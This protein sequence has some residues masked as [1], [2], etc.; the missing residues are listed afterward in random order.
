MLLFCSLIQHPCSTHGR[1]MTLLKLCIYH[2]TH[3]PVNDSYLLLFN[4]FSQKWHLNSLCHIILF[5]LL[6]V[7]GWQVD[8]LW[9]IAKVV[10]EMHLGDVF[11]IAWLWNT[12]PSCNRHRKENKAIKQRKSVLQ[13]WQGLS[14]DVGCPTPQQMAP[15]SWWPL[16]WSDCC[17]YL[18]IWF[19][20]LNLSSLIL[21][22]YSILMIFFKMLG[23]T[24][25]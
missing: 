18:C 16:S 12:R 23:V 4:V 22:C 9:I 3:R 6:C 25:E 5:L 21:V 17:G 1:S 24:Q 19:G 20:E 13:K 2:G 10:W 11:H 14:I 7:K 8:I 15:L